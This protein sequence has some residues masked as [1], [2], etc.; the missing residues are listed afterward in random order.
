MIVA[1]SD[2][3][4]QSCLDLEMSQEFS[5]LRRKVCLGDIVNHS[6]FACFVQLKWRVWKVPLRIAHA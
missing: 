6:H 1:Q 3:D 5:M 4:N 2:W